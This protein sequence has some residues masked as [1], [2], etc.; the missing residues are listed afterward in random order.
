MDRKGG[1][2]REPSQ[3]FVDGARGATKTLMGNYM[4]L[5]AKTNGTRVRRIVRTKKATARKR[6][7]PPLQKKKSKR[8]RGF[9]SSSRRHYGTWGAQKSQ[10]RHKRRQARRFY[11]FVWIPQR[12]EE[13]RRRGKKKK[14][15]STKQLG[16]AFGALQHAGSGFFLLLVLGWLWSWSG[17]T[18]NLT[19]ASGGMM[20]R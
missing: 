12:S 8:F 19:H 18:A 1:Q 20:S 11:Y 10:N 3:A 15:S 14:D 2:V 4:G 6:R 16:N 9:I 17:I 13:K 5:L 7:K